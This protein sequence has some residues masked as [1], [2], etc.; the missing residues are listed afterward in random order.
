MQ[1]STDIRM[2]LCHPLPLLRTPHIFFCGRSALPLLSLWGWV[3]FPLAAQAG[4]YPKSSMQ[5]SWCNSIERNGIFGKAADSFALLCFAGS[6]LLFTDTGMEI[7]S[8]A[9]IGC[10]F[11]KPPGLWVRRLIWKWAVC[12]SFGFG[13]S[14][15]YLLEMDFEN[16]T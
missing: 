1:L 16:E 3:N 6:C 4:S 11:P 7:F 14:V 5:K 10:G 2:S 15:C 9:H 13:R 8:Y 12:C